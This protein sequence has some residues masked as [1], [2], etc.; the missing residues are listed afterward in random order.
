LLAIFTF[1]PAVAAVPGFV[2]GIHPISAGLAHEFCS[3]V[4]HFQQ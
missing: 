3:V 2:E 4:F 1:I